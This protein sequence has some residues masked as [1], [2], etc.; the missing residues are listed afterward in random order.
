ME[1]SEL[2]GA[3]VVDAR[4]RRI[5]RL[6]DVGLTVTQRPRRGGGG[7]ELQVSTLLI[8]PGGLAE[9]LGYAYGPVEGPWLLRAL[10]HLRARHLKVA[11]WSAIS[12]IEDGRVTLSVAGD[13]LLHPER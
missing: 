6:R 8:G 11:P 13:D 2:L 3:D 7:L 9:R 1:L 5:G 12:R 4:G 10:L